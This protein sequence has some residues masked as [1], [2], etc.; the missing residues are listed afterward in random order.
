MTIRVRIPRSVTEHLKALIV[1]AVEGATLTGYG[2][3]VAMGWVF[4][5]GRLH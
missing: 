3:L 5:A 2:L 4:L 1:E